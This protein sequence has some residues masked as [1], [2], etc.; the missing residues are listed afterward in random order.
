MFKIY[1]NPVRTYLDKSYQIDIIDT[2]S[3]LW[4]NNSLSDDVNEN[5]TAVQNFIIRFWTNNLFYY[6][7]TIFYINLSLS[8]NNVCFD[9]RLLICCSIQYKISFRVILWLF[10]ISYIFSCKIIL[11]L[12]PLA[13]GSIWSKLN[14][15]CIGVLVFD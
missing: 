1:N 5:F 8:L 2:R 11:I 12:V 7:F 14:M 9:D 3:L 6:I 10:K 4:G 13:S 15:Y